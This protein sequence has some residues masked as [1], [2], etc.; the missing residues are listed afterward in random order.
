MFASGSEELVH[1]NSMEREEGEVEE[2]GRSVNSCFEKG[3]SPKQ[4]S[5][6]I[7]AKC[8]KGVGAN[9]GSSSFAKRIFAK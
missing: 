8:L 3:K 2:V 6:I 1:F 9:E 5:E 7:D 4:I